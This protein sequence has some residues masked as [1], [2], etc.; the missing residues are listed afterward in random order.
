MIQKRGKLFHLIRR[1]PTLYHDVEKRRLIHVALKT[2][3]EEDA[4]KKAVGVWQKLVEG[5]EA[6]LA[7]DTTDAEKSFEAA[8][9]IAK[10]KGFRFLD[11]PAVAA[12]PLPEFIERID[13]AHDNKGKADIVEAKALL[14]VTEKPAIT[15]S[16]ALELYWP[17]AAHKNVGKSDDQL[18]R[19]RNPHIKAIKNLINTIGDKPIEDISGDDMLDFCD[20]WLEK[21]ESEGLTP[22]SANKD[23]SHIGS[24][25]KTVNKKKRLG[26]VLPLSDLAFSQREKSQRPRF[27]TKWITEK[28]LAPDA[29]SGLNTEARCILLGMVNTG[30][31]PS[32]AEVLTGA[33]IKLEGK[34]PFIS[35]EPVGRQLK[36]QN[37]RRVIPLAGV[38]LA[39]F[40]ECPNGF[41]RYANSSSLTNTVRKFLI[42]NKL[43]ETSKHS[44]YSLRHSFEDRMTDAG[45]EERI[46]ADLMGHSLKRERYGKGAS[47]KKAH[48][49]VLQIAL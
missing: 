2:D 29:L 14:G 34:I 11:A 21:I 31:R 32:E 39:A 6:R 18:R 9:R 40:R 4:R 1:T 8:N 38:S 33:Q 5:W 35:I 20:W 42:E 27:S 22:N 12:L 46:K 45:I 43:R 3:S 47:L 15:I 44:M 30:Y 41:P 7:G 23:L 10:S 13:A 16:R 36:T 19:W 17:M 37:A 28:L 49:C 24:I 48:E 26:L 25:L